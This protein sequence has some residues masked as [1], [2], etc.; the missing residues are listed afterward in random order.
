MKKVLLVVLTILLGILMCVLSF[1]IDLEKICVNTLSS[2]VVNKQ[3]ASKTIDIIKELYP[4]IS[5]DELDK[6]E[7]N[8]QNSDEISR[9]TKI[10]FDAVL[11]ETDTNNVKAPDISKEVKLLIRENNK[12]INDK[13]VN[14]IIKTIEEEK[15]FDGVYEWVAT[16]LT[17]DQKEAI[18]IYKLGSSDTFKI[19]IG[20]LIG[21]TLILIMILLKSIYKW[22]LCA[23]VS[24]F[25]SG[26]IILFL[27]PKLL[28]NMSKK[29]TSSLIGTTSTININVLNNYGYIL[30][31]VGI[32][33]LIIYILIRIC[34]RKKA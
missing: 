25:I 28:D 5:N 29:I 18:T 3:I 15:T 24:S 6:I 17:D 14:M 13:Q 21:L 8:I 11:K 7:L 20:S 1:S 30:I 33:L 4:K 31:G 26:T 23:S 27:I 16:N 10:Y 9:I 32:A 22:M 2:N 34:V 19:V 12:Y